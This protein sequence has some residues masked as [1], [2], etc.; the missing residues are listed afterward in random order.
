[1]NRVRTSVREGIVGAPAYPP[2]RPSL[3][4]VARIVVRTPQT[5]L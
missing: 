3:P 1:M 4:V 2:L 5:A